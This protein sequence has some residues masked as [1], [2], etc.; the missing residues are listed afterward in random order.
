MTSELKR[1]RGVILGRLTRIEV[2]IRDIDSKSGL[3]EDHIQARLEIIDQCWAEYSTVQNNIDAG[4]DIDVEEEEEKRAAFEERCINARVAL[5]S[6]LR[7]MQRQGTTSDSRNIDRPLLPVQL[8]HQIP[9][10]QQ[11]VDVRL[12]TLE[13][14]TFGGDYMDWPGFRDAFQALIDRN[15]QLSNVQ[16][17]L[18]LKSTLKEEAAS[19]L[20]ALD[21][22]DANY[23]VAWDLLVEMFENRRVIKQKHLKALFTIKQVPED[24]PRELRRLLTEFQRNVNA[25]KQFGEPTEEWST[26]LVYLIAIKLDGTPRRDWETQTQDDESPTYEEIVKFI[27]KRCT[28]RHPAGRNEPTTTQR[29]GTS[30]TRKQ[31]DGHPL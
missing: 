16:K 1:L 18:Y 8:Q 15:M 9:V 6:A 7:R 19:V 11:S 12:P 4:E 31:P 13:L 25:L 23:Q 26:L 30:S 5:R 2:F 28:N 17:L 20:E 14:P 21:I 22:T 10:P 29:E 3:T 24:S 27:N